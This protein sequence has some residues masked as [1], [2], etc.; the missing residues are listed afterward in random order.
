MAQA[1]V[2]SSSH[3]A[4][5]R[6]CHCFDQTDEYDMLD[7]A[8]L[9]RSES[10]ME[11]VEFVHRGAPSFERINSYEHSFLR[12][13]MPRFT[14]EQFEAY[15]EGRRSGALAGVV[16]GSVSAAIMALM[17]WLLLG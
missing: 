10:P 11:T 5:L 14:P 12:F 13:A 8:L 17:L 3:T 6:L 2:S 7:T 16:V 9:Q 15:N 1:A 4:S